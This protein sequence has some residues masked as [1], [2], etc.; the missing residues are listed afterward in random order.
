MVE[1]IRSGPEMLLL[2]TDQETVVV[3]ALK[4]WAILGP[5]EMKDT[6]E[7]AGE[8]HT[9]LIFTRVG[10]VLKDTRGQKNTLV[11][12]G[13]AAEILAQLMNGGASDVIRKTRIVAR[14][15]LMRTMGDVEASFD[16]I[17]AD[18]GGEERSLTDILTQEEEKGVVVALTEQSLNRQVTLNDIHEEK[19]LFLHEDYYRIYKNLRADALKFLNIGLGNRDWNEF[20]I[21]I[22]DI[23]GAFALHYER[24]LHVLTSLE[25]G[26]VLGASWGKDYPRVLLA[27]D[28]YRVRLF[29]FRDPAV[30]KSILLGLEVLEDGTRIID[31]DLFKNRKKIYWQDLFRGKR[32]S[33]TEI[34]LEQRRRILEKLSDED[35]EELKRLEQKILKTRE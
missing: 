8:E 24:L 10:E 6:F 12:E 1:L 19:C 34:A 33:R 5:C 7:H 31:L 15:I 21:R 3:E 2:E 28:I 26:I 17:Q 27:I 29:T 23:Y 25:A 35:L 13:S 32:D 30:I 22:Y 9:L 20:E 4:E 14:I 16:A 18:Y 11:V